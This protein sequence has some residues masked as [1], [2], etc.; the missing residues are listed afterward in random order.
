M[1]QLVGLRQLGSISA[2]TT[3]EADISSGAHRLKHTLGKA[4]D[5]LEQLKVLQGTQKY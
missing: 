1:W 2:L 4:V 3:S 5:K